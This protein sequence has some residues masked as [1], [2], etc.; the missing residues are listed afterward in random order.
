MIL[1]MRFHKAF[2]LDLH[3]FFK[4][5]FLF[6]FYLTKNNTHATAGQHLR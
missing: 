6:L 2:H 1:I 5:C 3:F 4:V